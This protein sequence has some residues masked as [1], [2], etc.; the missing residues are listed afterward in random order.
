MIVWILGGVVAAAALLLAWGWFEAGWLRT[1]VLEVELEGVPP[2][3]DGVRI[4]HLSDFHLGVPS[5]GRRAVAAPRRESSD[6][7]PQPQRRPADSV[8]TDRR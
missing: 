8:S 7:V 4:A 5:R 6:P 3:L 2:A 1:R